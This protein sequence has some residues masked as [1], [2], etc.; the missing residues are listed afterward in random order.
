MLHQAPQF[1]PIAPRPGLL[2]FEQ[3]FAASGI[4]LAALQLQ[5]LIIGRDASISNQ[6]VAD[7]VRKSKLLQQGFATR[8]SADGMSIA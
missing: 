2:L 1:R 3:T 4:E 5:I 7:M 6:H 8:D